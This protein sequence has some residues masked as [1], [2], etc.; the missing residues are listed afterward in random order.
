MDGSMSV[1][2]PSYAGDPTGGVANQSYGVAAGATGVMPTRRIA[3][4]SSK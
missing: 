2:T 1:Y 3:W 4:K